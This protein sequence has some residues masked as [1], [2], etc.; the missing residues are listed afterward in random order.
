MKQVTVYVIVNVNVVKNSNKT[1]PI[2]DA[3]YKK[4][5]KTLVELNIKNNIT[6]QQL[7]K[8]YPKEINKL[9]KM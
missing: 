2:L 9:K 7:T 4:N 6:I 1:N 5:K 3:F 8:K